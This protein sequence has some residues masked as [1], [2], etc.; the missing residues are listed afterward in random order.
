MPQVGGSTEEE[1]W[2][3]LVEEMEKR[4]A[5]ERKQQVIAIMYTSKYVLIVLLQCNI[6]SSNRL[7]GRMKEPF[8]FFFVSIC[9]RL[10]RCRRAA[11]LRWGVAALWAWRGIFVVVIID[12]CHPQTVYLPGYEGI[13][14]WLP[15][16]ILFFIVASLWI[17]H[18]SSV[19]ARSAFCFCESFF[20]R[21][22]LCPIPLRVRFRKFRRD[23]LSYYDAYRALTKLEHAGDTS[24]PLCRSAMC[25]RFPPNLPRQIFV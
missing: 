4:G 18:L 6:T 9:G 12:W 22:L 5:K 23:D 2:R 14:A 13:D 15:T 8:F 20:H 11:C 17:E 7:A 25:P 19:G 24:Q 1:K 16:L 10:D 21:T 3:E